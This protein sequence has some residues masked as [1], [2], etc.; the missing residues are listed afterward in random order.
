M[1]FRNCG[2][3]VF[4][5]MHADVTIVLLQ[6][7]MSNDRTVLRAHDPRSF[8]GSTQHHIDEMVLVALGQQYSRDGVTALQVGNNTDRTETG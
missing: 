6:G 4:F 8:A 5:K 3:A 7:S 1:R 2:Q